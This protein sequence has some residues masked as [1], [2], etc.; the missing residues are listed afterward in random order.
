MM[1]ATPQHLELFKKALGAAGIDL[2]VFK[3]AGLF[4]SLDAD[5]TLAAFMR[6][7]GLPDYSL[8]CE[9]VGGVLREIRG[10]HPGSQ[11]SAYGEMVNLLWQRGNIE[12]A[13]QLEKYWNDLAKMHSFSL[14][15]AYSFS[16]KKHGLKAAAIKEICAVHSHF[17]PDENNE[18]MEKSVDRAVNEVLRDK[19][20]VLKTLIGMISK[21]KKLRGARVPDYMATLLW[22]EDNMPQTA[23]KVKEKAAQYLSA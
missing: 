13:I 4:R 21:T 23:A 17:I 22:L 1:I 19:T 5:E 3:T 12:G 16:K 2:D 6:P 18:D 8:F 10:A 11:I 20:L 15:C 9:I 14:F 7:D